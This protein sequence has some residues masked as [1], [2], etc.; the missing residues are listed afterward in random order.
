MGHLFNRHGADR[1]IP[2]FDRGEFPNERDKLAPAQVGACAQVEPPAPGDMASELFGDGG[3]AHYAGLPAFGL[4][5]HASRVAPLREAIRDEDLSWNYEQ[6]NHDAVRCAA[7]FQ[8]LGVRP[9]DRVGIL[10]PNVPE[11]AIA[12][13]GVWRAGGIGVA[14]SP[15][16]VREEVES[17]LKATGCRF[18]VCLDML[19]HLVPSGSGT[20]RL[21]VSI[22]DRLSALEQLG[23]LWIRHR[24][25]GRW[26]LP[27]GDENLWFWEQLEGARRE[28]QPVAIHPAKDP[29]CILPTGGTTGRPKA[30]T[31]SHQNLVANAWQ[32]AEWTRRSFAE[33]TMMAVLPFFHSYGLSAV[34]MG[35][36]AMAATLVLQHRFQARQLIRQIET[37]RP[38][39]L[40]A[41]PAMLVA[42][43]ERLRE[44]PADLRSLK[45]V[46]SGGAPLDEAVAA[47]FS[48]LS[49]ALVVEG[50]GLSEAS[51]VT[52]VGPLFAAP[53]C[54]SIGLALPETECR[55][56]DIE[57]GTHVVPAGET[58]EL[59]VRGPQVMLGYWDDADATDGVIRDGWLSTGDLATRGDDG[60]YRIVGRK[61]DLIITSGFNVHPADVEEVV[62][63]S[64]AGPPDAAN[65]S[66][67]IA[68]RAGIPEDR[69]AHTVHRN[70]DSG[71]NSV[72]PTRF[73]D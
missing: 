3:V 58:G 56:V 48:R 30:V 15:L 9:G 6:L 69:P 11:Y 7:M 20:R 38:T 49:G 37:R 25:T 70:C 14:I 21:L 67:V 50:Y 45:W 33:E 60:M 29:A 19:S 72:S 61:K 18:V 28:W 12:L 26:S 4:L 24:R 54:G 63:G 43:N 41:V 5:R 51:P 53:S 59:C 40:H 71:S 68:L 35:G 55:I 66:R 23:Y 17:L 36:M 73:R 57:T 65:L 46:I 64:V 47:E 22:R 62:F 39:L 16:M 27:T 10:L 2:R 31:L 52:H 42:L 32:Q 1:D 13:H 44:R 34:M 8:G